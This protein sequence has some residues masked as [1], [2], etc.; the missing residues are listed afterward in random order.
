MHG[1]RGRTLL[2]DLICTYMVYDIII[3]NS[4]TTTTRAA[5]RTNYYRL[6]TGLHRFARRYFVHSTYTGCSLDIGCSGLFVQTTILYYSNG[7]SAPPKLPESIWRIKKRSRLN[8]KSKLS[9]WK[10]KYSKPAC[11]L[12]FV[13]SSNKL[14]KVILE[15]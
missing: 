4:I 15:D 1:S 5:L 6:V 11:R 8:C 12:I 9:L 10:Y 2:A 7:S 13:I 14:G 3:P